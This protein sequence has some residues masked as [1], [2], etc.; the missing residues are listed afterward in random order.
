MDEAHVIIFVVDGKKGPVDS[1][2]YIAK[3]LV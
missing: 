3:Q 1:D 2:Y